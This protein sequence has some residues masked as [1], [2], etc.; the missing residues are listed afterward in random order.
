MNS[1]TT[2]AFRQCLAALP[3]E[4]RRQ[5]VKAY[6]LWRSDPRHPSLQF[7]Q[8]HATKGIWSVRIALGWRAL[9]VLKDGE[10]VWFW[11]GS[12]ADYDRLIGS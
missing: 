3:A 1:R 8:I 11:V 2:R 4:V 7:K 6:R 12:H 5:A 10:I 9:G